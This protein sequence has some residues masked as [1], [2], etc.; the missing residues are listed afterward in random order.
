MRIGRALTLLCALGCLAPQA[1]RAD[2]DPSEYEVKTAVRTAKERKQLE[3]EFEVDRKREAER[4]KQEEEHEVR[5]LAV[6]RAAWEVLPYPLR[7][8][9]MRCAVCHG[10]DLY[11]SQ[12]HNRIGWELV[13]LRMEFLDQT[14]L[15]AGERS[16]ITAHLAQ[17][18]PATGTEALLEVLQQLA[19]VLFPL[20]LWI[21]WK[22]VRSGAANRKPS[23]TEEN[24]AN[25]TPARPNEKRRFIDRR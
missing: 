19:V 7:L 14:R 17:A 23:E 25:L 11:E 12:R 4:Q 3:A 9:R 5:R 8:T 15:D 24:R 10:A 16:L 20:G 21:T 1:S 13:V 18:Y 22:M 2:I 6:E